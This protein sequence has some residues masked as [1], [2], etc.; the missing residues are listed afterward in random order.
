MASQVSHEEGKQKN[1]LAS[2]PTH[3][4][5]ENEATA[6]K[7]TKN[8]DAFVSLEMVQNWKKKYDLGKKEK[9]LLGLTLHVTEEGAYRFEW[10]A[11]TAFSTLLSAIFLLFVAAPMGA[12]IGAGFLAQV[13]TVVCTFTT[14]GAT[15]NA[16]A[17]VIVGATSAAILTWITNLLFEG[18]EV[19]SA[20]FLALIAFGYA[21]FDLHP[22]NKRL[23]LALAAI[24]ILAVVQDRDLPA[25]FGFFL[26]FTSFVGCILS[27]IA[28]LLPMPKRTET[29]V[30]QKLHHV[31]HL[32]ASILDLQLKIMFKD[33]PMSID[34]IKTN[35]STSAISCRGVLV[36]QQTTLLQA[37]GDELAQLGA[38]LPDL[39]WEPW[40]TS[41]A[42]EYRNK[43]RA[44]GN[45][46]SLMQHSLSLAVQNVSKIHL[47]KTDQR[48]KNI[49]ILEKF[50][51]KLRPS[52][53]AL[54]TAL[55]RRLIL[56]EPYSF[57]NTKKTNESDQFAEADTLIRKRFKDVMRAYFEA[58]ADY[59]YADET[60]ILT[61]KTIT[62]LMHFNFLL[63]SIRNTT[64]AIRGNPV[65]SIGNL[66]T[67]AGKRDSLDSSLE[68]RS[69]KG[70]I[71]PLNRGKLI[72]SESSNGHSPSCCLRKMKIWIMNVWENRPTI[73]CRIPE[74]PDFNNSIINAV[75]V[76]LA[77]SL[78]SLL[79]LIPSIRDEF[80]RAFWGPLTIAF[81]MGRSV[82]ASFKQSF[83][84]MQ[85]TV[86]GVIFGYTL[87][88]LTGGHRAAILIGLP[89][90]VFVA[91]LAKP[92]KAFGYAGVV[93]A[94]TS[95]VIVLGYDPDE[96]SIG[97]YSLARIELTALGILIW[98][99]I[100]VLLF[101]FSPRAELQKEVLRSFPVVSQWIYS[102]SNHV[103]NAGHVYE[104]P[105]KE[106]TKLDASIR[107]QREYF[108]EASLT[109][110]LLDSEFPA[111]SFAKQIR[112]LVK[113]KRCLDAMSRVAQEWDANKFGKLT[114]KE[115][116]VV[117]NLCAEALDRIG[118]GSTA[119]PI[120]VGF[121]VKLMR[122]RE[123]L[124]KQ[125]VFAVDRVLNRPQNESK[126]KADQ[127][128]DVEVPRIHSEPV[129]KRVHNVLEE[130][131][132]TQRGIGLETLDLSLPP[133]QAD[134]KIREES[135]SL[136]VHPHPHL[137]TMISAI[138]VDSKRKFS[139]TI[140]KPIPKL[141]NMVVFVFMA[142]VFHLNYLVDLI[143]ELSAA[144]R[145]VLIEDH[146]QSHE[147]ILH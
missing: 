135:E 8:K 26:L 140:W 82:G 87:L 60:L 16:S 31:S 114:Q 89:F 17:Q 113:I 100:C 45:V 6:K 24:G 69:R 144:T 78:S 63:F 104:Y 120:S 21:L 29:D 11:R 145:D 81:V 123:E 70:S 7:K 83:L 13:V 96:L 101:P 127:K 41:V 92:S 77:I 117:H 32:L 61:K 62:K 133:A 97:E 36:A 65:N 75:K 59:L 5:K 119:H 94:F 9:H 22:L 55:K 107:K 54:F 46:Y 115:L 95:G 122:A 27:I 108:G 35:G 76:S 71:A 79:V 37:V 134:E 66:Y 139:D 44:L 56:L 50:L 118:H 80:D 137:T 129:K 105:P 39:K 40:S 18:G 86:S 23:G 138:D 67:N 15:I 25:T 106:L 124:W 99:A 85:G 130:H 12:P 91:S 88:R 73:L 64:K 132:T 42:E 143:G 10:A 131:K 74:G 116:K 136:H 47:Q 141:P 110:S 3:S 93:A 103:G 14:L 111:R 49:E 68:T 4:G 98:F 72:S 51:I 33:I 146:L 58:R 125:L 142:Y 112:C 147:G 43:H 90:I 19:G 20:I 102:I 1:S 53:T 121:E 84:R 128:D 126:A 34:E 52:V 28:V 38:L 30:Y 2:A 57:H 48:N 109:P